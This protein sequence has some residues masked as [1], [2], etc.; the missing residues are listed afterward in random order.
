MLTGH[1]S[2][3]LCFSFPSSLKK[4]EEEEVGEEVDACCFVASN[5]Y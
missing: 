2:F 3:I 1:N 5:I 4:K